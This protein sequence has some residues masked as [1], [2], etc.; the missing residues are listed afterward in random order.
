MT[1]YRWHKSV[2]RVN[3]NS[4]MSAWRDCASVMLLPHFEVFCYLVLSL[5]SS[6]VK[7]WFIN[8]ICLIFHLLQC[9]HDVKCARSDAETRDHPCNFEQRVQLA[10]CQVCNERDKKVICLLLRFG[11]INWID[12]TNW[13]PWSNCKASILSICPFRHCE[14]DSLWQRKSQKLKSQLYNIFMLANLCYQASW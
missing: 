10:L 6:L 8:F 13:P 3:Q 9:P 1:D 7:D 5:L 14:L 12:K 4:G 2:V 11:F